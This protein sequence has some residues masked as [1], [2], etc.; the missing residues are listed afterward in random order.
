V[1]RLDSSL[2]VERKAEPNWQPPLQPNIDRWKEN[3]YPGLVQKLQAK[4][5]L[6]AEEVTQ[7]LAGL[8]PGAFH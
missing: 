8:Q 7:R 2:L 4:Y 3:F 6:S 5:Q 1:G